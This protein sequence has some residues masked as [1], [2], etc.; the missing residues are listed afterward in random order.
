[1]RC[2]ALAALACALAC[3]TAHA[4]W[5]VDAGVESYAW[6]EATT[7][8]EVHEHG[9]RFSFGAGY[10]QPRQQGLLFAYRGELYGGKVDYNGSFQFDATQAAS[11]ASVYLGTTQAAQA[12]WRWPATA[13]AVLGLEYEAWT[14]HLTTTQEENYRTVSLRLGVERVASATSRVV[15]GGGMRFLLATGEDATI[16]EAGITYALGLEPGRDSNPF[17]HA[18]YRVM[19]HV[20]LLGTW[21]GMR[22]GRSNEVVLFKRGKPRAVVSQPPSDAT[23]LGVRVVYGW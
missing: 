8:I 1:M 3:S 16:E 13:D 7:P 11:G 15:A 23:R 18:G 6:R 2:I 5:S 19:P 20:T 10:V 17:L 22:F 21:D 14:R 4:R 9:P 12:R